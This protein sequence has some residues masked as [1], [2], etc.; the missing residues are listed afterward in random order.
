MDDFSRKKILSVDCSLGPVSVALWRGEGEIDEIAESVTNYKSDILL[1]LI[2]TIIR[3][4]NLQAKDI[5]GILFSNGPGSF[6]GLRVGCSVCQSMVS[7]LSI[8]AYLFSTPIAIA[9]NCPVSNASVTVV[10][11]A[12]K[13]LLYL[14]EF[15]VKDGQPILLK[16]TMEISPKDCL[17]K[18][19]ENQ[20]IIGTGVES[21]RKLVPDQT[22]NTLNLSS[23]D[24]IP[25]AG[26]TLEAW[27][28]GKIQTKP[29]N[30]VLPY[31]ISPPEAEINYEKKFGAYTTNQ[32]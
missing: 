21:F 12:Y 5:D 6:T 14:T 19:D 16:N 25:R 7:L 4:N 11:Q 30:E 1:S 28:A 31:Y 18:I 24:H 20:I 26:K 27:L 29:V 13:G 8:P 32:E 10:Q 17:E 9:L 23:T 22:F 15:D 3:R 2:D